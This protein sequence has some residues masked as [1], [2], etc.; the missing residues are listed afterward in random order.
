V[1]RRLPAN[2]ASLHF[3]QRAGS[4]T[5]FHADKLAQPPSFRQLKKAV[6]VLNFR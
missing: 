2:L 6:R 1:A 3:G 5:Q 4:Q